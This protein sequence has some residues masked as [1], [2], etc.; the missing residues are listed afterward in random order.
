VDNRHF[1]SDVAFGAAVG[2]SSGWTVVG[3]RGRTQH[4]ALEP[5]PIRG[6]IMIAFTRV[7]N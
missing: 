4:V 2:M 7:D 3:T 6:G 5:V 1:V